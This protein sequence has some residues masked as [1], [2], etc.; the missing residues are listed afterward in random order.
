[1]TSKYIKRI[2]QAYANGVINKYMFEKLVNAVDEAIDNDV[3]NELEQDAIDASEYGVSN[4]NDYNTHFFIGHFIDDILDDTFGVKVS[5][6]EKKELHKYL[7]SNKNDKYKLDNLTDY[8]ILI[9]KWLCSR[10][11]K[12]AYPNI[13]GK[14]E[15]DVVYDLDKWIS[16]LKSIYS[17]LKNKKT[18]RDSVIN[19]HTEGWDID[20][21]SK[22]INWMKYYEGGNTE[23]YNVKNAK[24][25]K[26]AEPDLSIP[27]SWLYNN[28]RRDGNNIN[29][30]TYKPDAEKT[31]R[32]QEL[33]QAMAFKKQMRARLLSLKRLLNKY[34]DI[35]P[36]QNLEMV[37]DEMNNLEKSI[38]KLNAYATMQ[39]CVVR[40]ANRI[41]R[42]GFSEGANYLMKIAEDTAVGENVI[43][44][45]PEAVSN[46]PNMQEGRPKFTVMT[47]I[48]RLE[49][50]SKALKSRDM[51]RELASIDILLNEMGMASYF[52]ELTDAQSK[53]I[54]SFGYASNKIEAIVAKLRGSGTSNPNKS[55]P[56]S[57]N[58]TLIPGAPPAPQPVSLSKPE[59][60]KEPIDTEEIMTKPVSEVKTEIPKKL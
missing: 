38:S 16:T 53:L 14:Q 18:S 43:K 52:P 20:E 30:S 35:L 19:I 59:A 21:K 4:D 34:N 25:K 17:M 50:T 33:Q 26:E 49:G 51:I 29:M 27:S 3:Y 5:P 55:N 22:F 56:P 24:L 57:A 11:S 31:K 28:E 60:P 44:S 48:S 40:S 8:R 15:K 45:I 36:S 10:L 41:N 6:V 37:H 9:H 46:E 12:Q 58:P 1:M 47:I 54:E 2:T 7:F 32:E 39:D 13:A 23:K 42:F